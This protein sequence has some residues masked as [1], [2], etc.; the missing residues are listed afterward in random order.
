MTLTQRF[1]KRLRE[2]LKIELPNDAKMIITHAGYWQ[3]SSGAYT[4]YIHSDSVWNLE[5]GLYEP[6]TRLMKC[7][8]LI[9]D[10][11]SWPHCNHTVECGCKGKCKESRRNSTERSRYNAQQTK[12]KIPAVL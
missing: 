10:F 2:E 11:G 12:A 3:R 1:F 7:P 4:S 9:Q 8:N 6:I 5:I